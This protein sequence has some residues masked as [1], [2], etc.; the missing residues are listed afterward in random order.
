VKPNSG[1]VTAIV[2]QLSQNEPGRNIRN[3]SVLP[4]R[5]LKKSCETEKLPLD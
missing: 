3:P 2:M 5:G 4:E 1:A